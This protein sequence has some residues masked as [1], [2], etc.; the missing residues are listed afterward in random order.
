MG[1]QIQSKKR[2]EEMIKIGKSTKEREKEK[3][4][5]ALKSMMEKQPMSIKIS[6]P[7]F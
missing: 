5:G 2:T 7:K 6:M 4:R 1:N 3:K